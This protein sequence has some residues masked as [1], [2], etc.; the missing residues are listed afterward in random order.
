[1]SPLNT[2]NLHQ[3]FDKLDRNGDGFLSLDEITWLLDRIGAKT[4]EDELELLL[5]RKDLDRVDF[6]IFCDIVIKG[7]K[8]SSSSSV[9]GSVIEGGGEKVNENHLLEKDLFK[10][11]EVFDLNGDGFISSEEL[12][13]ALCNLGLLDEK[14][15]KDCETMIKV[16]DSNCDGKLDFEEFKNMM[17][18]PS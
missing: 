18:S 8:N 3:I 6:A 10:A 17:F 1:M 15:D 11:F 7:R 9:N 16:Y 14:C 5:G 13:N 12:E 4:T 2:S